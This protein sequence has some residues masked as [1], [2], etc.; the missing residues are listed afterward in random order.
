ML[1]FVLRHLTAILIIVAIAVWALV[2]LPQSPSFAVFRMKQAIDAR[3]GDAAA[4]YVDFESVVKHAGYE[5]VQKR[6]GGDPMSSMIG[7]AAIDLFTKP[8]AQIAKAWSVRKVN[9]GDKDVQMPDAAVVGAIVL[10]H[11]SGDTAYTDFKD[12]KGQE[13]EIHLAR[14]DDGQWRVVEIKNVEQ[15]L[16]KLQREEDKNLNAP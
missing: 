11:R 4:N 8:M 13:W 1:R 2:Y 10:L 9:D 5:M 6:G 15:L 16:E 14:G 7:N 12:H 3:N